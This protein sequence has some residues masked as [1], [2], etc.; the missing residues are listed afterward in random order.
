MA[1]VESYLTKPKTT[2]ISKLQ[3]VV[4]RNGFLEEFDLEKLHGWAEWAC[5]TTQSTDWKLIVRNALR[6]VS[7]ERIESEQLQ[8]LLIQAAD[9]L[10]EHHPEYDVPARELFLARLRKQVYDSFEP[11]SLRG[12]YNKLV[13]E[14]VWE[15]MHW[16]PDHYWPHLEEAIDHERDR[17]FTYSGIKQYSDKY[18]RRN[19]FTDE[20]YETPQFTYMGMAM[21][22]AQTGHWTLTD[23]I[24]LYDAFSLQRVNVPTPPL[25][26][27]RTTDR[28]FA[29][30]CLMEAADTLDSIDAAEHIIFKMVAARAG[31]GYLLRSRANGD[32]IRGGSFFSTGKLPYLRHALSSTM[33]NTQQS[34]GGSMTANIPFFDA[35]IETIIAAKSQRSAAEDRLD[36]SDF[37]IQLGG[38]LFERIVQNKPITLMS[39]FHAPEVFDAFVD[40]EG[41]PK[42]FKEVYEAAEARLVGKTRVGKGGS[43]IPLVR[44]VPAIEVLGAALSVKMETGRFYQQFMDNTNSHSN[45]NEPI[46]MT[47]LCVEINQPTYP[48]NHV[49]ELYQTAEQLK[50]KKPGEIGEVSLCNL[51]GFVLGRTPDNEKER[52]YYVLLKFVDSIIEIQ[53]Y[54]FPA[55]EFTAKARRNIGIGV[56]NAA[57]A[58]A[59]E[60]LQF[61]GVE[62]RNWMHKQMEDHAYYLH[63]A[64]VQLAKEQGPALWFKYTNPA[65]GKLVID[66][67][68][69][70]VDSLV[71]VGLR[72]DWESLRQD[73]LKY[74]MRNSVLTAQMPGESSSVVLGVTN[75]INPIRGIVVHKKSGV[76]LVPQVAYG[77]VDGT[78]QEDDYKFAFDI[79]KVEWIKFV[80]VA[81]KF[82]SQSI[83]ADQWF[84]YDDYPD[85]KIPIPELVKLLMLC[86]QLGWKSIYYAWFEAGNGGSA[87]AV[88]DQGCNSGGCTL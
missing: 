80:A 56:M 63:K 81:Q 20:I 58:M 86:Y 85:G 27:L 5:A 8:T 46:K 53:D 9:A 22:V 26:G 29:S 39:I 70:T 88:D 6:H 37:V 74:G 40:A 28:G 50:D 41:D 31:I 19:Y 62:A 55:M 17:L 34:R 51:G 68:K 52:I 66:T 83:S 7:K 82:F 33:A 77:I 13:E 30:C 78:V 87:H 10:I 64:S 69:K 79:D 72:H 57:G 16:I 76:N 42:K 21:A 47:N 71:T 60:G 14:G 3:Y 18:A 67:Y 15:D 23:I 24:D 43:R 75:S 1:G 11:P 35:E 65:N 4:K 2:R 49:T 73:I 38:V 84:R 36:K 48:F 32:P 61:E 54:A 12:W 59:A 45:F 44:Q 25:V